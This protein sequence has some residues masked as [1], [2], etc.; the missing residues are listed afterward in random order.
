MPHFSRFQRNCHAPFKCDQ[1]DAQLVR[2]LVA[3][4]NVYRIVLCES[5]VQQEMIS[6]FVTVVAD[7]TVVATY[8]V[9]LFALGHVT[10]LT[11]VNR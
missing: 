7:A 9:R 3:I 2:L 8:A 5:V 10:P 1:N 11:R 6:F 4:C